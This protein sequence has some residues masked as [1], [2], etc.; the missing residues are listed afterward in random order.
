MS[1]GNKKTVKRYIVKRDLKGIFPKEF[2][3][4]DLIGKFF[5]Y[6]MNNFFEKS[7][8][9]YIN[10]Y[11]GKK[12]QTLE[13]GNFYVTEPTAERQLYQL[14]PMLV[15][16]D[17]NNNIKDIV[18]YTNFIN[19]LKTQGALTNDHNRLLSNK[20]WSYAP[21]INID[22]FLNFNFYYWIEE[23]VKPI[24]IENVVDVDNNGKAGEIR[25][26]NVVVNLIGRKNYTYN[27]LNNYDEVVS[28]PVYN[29][30]RIILKNDS[31]AEYNDKP[32]IIE[33]VG[34]S[35]IL[36][37]DSEIYNID[38]DTSPDYFVMERGAKDENPWSLRNRWFHI[39]D[40]KNANLINQIDADKTKYVQAKKP[41]LCFNKD[42]ELYNFGSYGR[43]WVDVITSMHKN[44]FNGKILNKNNQDGKLIIGNQVLDTGAKILFIDEPIEEAN[45]II[46][47]L[48]L[49]D[50]GD[51]NLITLYP[52]VNGR[53]PDGKA[54]I[55]DC[56]KVRNRL[57]NCYHFDGK[58][59]ILSQ[60][61]TKVCQSPLFNLYDKNKIPLDDKNIYPNSSFR[62]CT[63]FN[64]KPVTDRKATIDEDLK[65]RYSSDGY[66][67]YIFINS[68]VSDKITYKDITSVDIKVRKEYSGYKYYKINDENPSYLN[69]WI[70]SNDNLTQYI[71]SEITVKNNVE[72]AEFYDEKNLPIYYN[73]FDLAYE[74]SINIY[75]KNAF[76]YVN[77]QILDNES[78]FIDNYKLY[79][80]QKVEL[81]EFDTIFIK[82]LINKIGNEINFDVTEPL[83][84]YTKI[85]KD[86][87][88]TI[89]NVFQLNHNYTNYVEKNNI[90]LYIND[91]LISEGNYFIKNY[92]LYINENINVKENDNIS[93]KIVNN[94]NN[95]ELAD[96]YVY[97]IPLMLSANCLNE[98]IEEIKYNE[99]FSHFESI[100]ENQKNFEGA[101]NGINNYNDTAKDISLG[102]KI[103]QHSTPILKTM[104]LNSK[105]YTN[106]KTVLTY[107]CDEYTRFKNRYNLTINNF[108]NNG[109]YNEYERISDNTKNLSEYQSILESLSQNKN[110]TLEESDPKKYMIKALNLLNVGK[111]GLHPFY[112]NGVAEQ[113]INKDEDDV[114]YLPELYIPSTP[115]YLG[116]DNCYK[117]RFLEKTSELKDSVLLCHDGS[118]AKIYH[119]YRDEAL[120]EIEEEIYNSIPL[121]IKEHLPCIIKQKYIPGRFR[122]TEYSYENYIKLYTPLFEKW[123]VKNDLDYT[124]NST[125]D[126]YNSFTWN[127]STCYDDRGFKLPGSYHGIYMYYY[128]TDKPHTN[129]WEMLGFGDKPEW[130]E[131]HYG[132]AP[133]TSENYP[134]WKDIEEGHIIDG[135]SKGYY[136]EFKRPGL[137]EKYLPVDINGNLL[138][139]Y[140]AGIAT[141]KPII[142][143]ASD[144]WKIGD[145]GN[146][147]NSWRYTSEYRYDIQTL[148][149]LMKPLEWVETTWD[150]VN[151]DILFKNTNYE[152][153]INI[154]SNLRDIQTD[155]EMHNELINDE[156]VRK[157]GSQQWIS[158]F[159]T[160]ENINITNYIANDLRNMNV[161][162]G[163]RCAGFFDK[164]SMRLMS[165]NYGLIPDNNYHLNMN[166]RF[167]G[168]IFNYSA[169][170]I[171]KYDNT[172][173]LDGYDTEHPYF[174]VLLPKK[175]GK[176]ST[177]E[178]DGRN[179]TY[180]H[181]YLN[182]SQPIRYK[183]VFTSA[184]ELY[185][186]IVGYG[187]YLESIGFVFN[188]INSNGE[189]IDFTTKGREYLIWYNN[190]E[191]TSGMSLILNPMD[192]E[193]NFKHSGFVDKVGQFINGK[194]SVTDISSYP[195][196]NKDLK[197]Y[198][199][200]G[201]ITIKPKNIDDIISNVKLLTSE[202]E[203]IMI[204][205]NETIYG[206][207]LYN[208]LKGTKTERFKLLGIKANGWNGTYYAPGYVFDENNILIS[209]Y[210]KLAN[211]FNYVYDTDDIRSFGNMGEEAKKTIGYHKT[212]YMENLLIDNRNMFNFYKGMLKEKGTRLAFN[213]LNRSTHIMSEGSSKL[214]L[215]E[216]WAFNVGHFG[217]TKNKSTL[218]FHVDAESINHDPQIITFSTD[219]N[220]TSTDISNIAINWKNKNWLK[221]NDNQDENTFHY[222]PYSK[223]LTIGGFAQLN[224]VN[225]ILDT[226][227][228]L[229]NN[230]DNINIGEKVWVVK[231]NEYT[232]NI[233]KK[234]DNEINPLKSLKVKDFNGLLSYDCH[235]LEKGDLIYVQNDILNRWI[236][237]LS[238]DENGKE[239]NIYINDPN[240]LTHNPNYN[241][242]NVGWSVFEYNGVIP[243]SYIIS[244]PN[245]LVSI[246]NDTNTYAFK[247]EKGV[248]INMPN[249]LNADGK[250]IYSEFKLKEPLNIKLED[251]GK[252][253][254]IDDTN[255]YYLTSYFHN[256]SDEPLEEDLFYNNFWYNPKFNT[257]S[258]FNGFYWDNSNTPLYCWKNGDNKVYTLTYTPG[259]RYAWEYNNK[260]V[261][262][263]SEYPVAGNEMYNISGKKVNV[264]TS[265]LNSN[266]YFYA[267]VLIDDEIVNAKY[268]RNPEM[269]IDIAPSPFATSYNNVPV[270][271]FENFGNIKEIK[272]YNIKIT[273][274]YVPQKFA[275][276]NDNG[277]YYTE[278]EYPVAGDSVY[279]SNNI[280]I[281]VVTSYFNGNDFFYVDDV[282]YIRDADNDLK[283]YVKISNT[284]YYR[285]ED[286]D[287]SPNHYSLI[288]E[289]KIDVNTDGNFD[290]MNL[291]DISIN[292]PFILTRVEQKPINIDLINSAYLLDDT[293][294]K[295][296]AQLHLYDPLHGILPDF[297]S[298]EIDY[299]T[300]YDPVDYNN[301][302]NWFDEKVGRLWWDT[303]K[304]RYI[305]YYQ[306]SLKYRRDNWGKQLPGSEIAI[307]EWSKSTILPED[308]GNQPY[309]TREVYN[310]ETDKND[311]FY[312]FWV[313]NPTEIPYLDFRTTSAYDISRKIN[314]PQDEGI[315]WFSPI[316]LVDRIYNDS[317]F[318][319]GNFD[320]VTTSQNF[321]I[322]INFKNN[323]E[324]DNHDE[325][326]MIVEDSSDLIPDPLWNK[327]KDSLIT[328]DK[329]NDEVPDEDLTD[330]EKTGITIRP[331]QSMFKNIIKARRNFVDVC[332]DIFDS[333]AID[334][335]TVI[336]DIKDLSVKDES[337]K[338]YDIIDTFPT[339]NEMISTPDKM[340]VGN[341]I[342]VEHDE[343]YD[344]IWTLWKCETL[345]EFTLIDYQKYSMDRYTYLIDAYINKKYSKDVYDKKIYF[346]NLTSYLN[347]VYNSNAKN[348]ITLKDGYIIRIDDS[349]TKEWLYL[350]QYNASTNTFITVGVR[351]GYIQISDDLYEYMENKSLLNNY[352][353]KLNNEDYEEFIDGLTE[354]EYIDREVKILIEIICDYFNKD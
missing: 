255:N 194:W 265:S 137:I 338:N 233:Y 230:I 318:I 295:T 21:P 226:K 171:T 276:K 304:V 13:E 252:Y 327:M 299:I 201:Y 187:K 344:N 179:F 166:Q 75:K 342:L 57:N 37:D 47:E 161:Q 209:D 52:V 188:L 256:S 320:D 59:W 308:I 132:P 196:Y 254:F 54:L 73:V 36:V 153:I 325:W 164:G 148:L 297:I 55:G 218:E 62:G 275:W 247:V 165:D 85:N 186:T 224:D 280:K 323:S 105:E 154:N 108:V 115:A 242:K 245:G 270:Y 143:Y 259:I 239:L 63:I 138:P 128:D 158:D 99:T 286:D 84:K 330:N 88:T 298:K 118:Y 100:L 331:R 25:G 136:E 173:V 167:T 183:T 160:S 326:F 328:E 61:K 266:E 41:I 69:N 157:M 272:E 106:I 250:Y 301:S 314:S 103:L 32:F 50:N 197:I 290:K 110:T 310:P 141:A 185:N 282:K 302:N 133:Y 155:I 279:D 71:I 353:K 159:L 7:Y 271:I 335:V 150:S 127:W 43:G 31:N 98:D 248:Y 281:N 172:W 65:R 94:S 119:D 292:N 241:I 11:I 317:S 117:P 92:S 211:D 315:I 287:I 83:E 213:K 6:V 351:D 17:S 147:E 125:F 39:N 5:D 1:I 333:R 227:D 33:G 206:D 126:E 131:E 18:D 56:I 96:G 28:I 24:I 249:G 70:L 319:I 30:M 146:V 258:R 236:T 151:T 91:N 114:Y 251:S 82:L 135:L 334:Y 95:E 76:V 86:E 289:T 23:G 231:D 288:A 257:L 72:V 220:Y 240:G 192:I 144:P 107:I 12:T 306:G 124:V 332:N 269:D 294:D 198:R 22:M 42:I 214:N 40:I 130:W 189:N 129:P 237:R 235:Y 16:Y 190:E 180:Y 232:W 81:K 268:K 212:K 300:S 348:P 216:H 68:I 169:M 243:Y 263:E 274:P 45:N 219:P 303:S 352:N 102:T 228:N 291:V 113:L 204:I 349:S 2:T 311:I 53:D 285:D 116:L 182:V 234:V 347:R 277:V 8:E 339:H 89:Y 170:I 176:T 313:L 156:Y 293:I 46:Y 67:N 152:Q 80:T 324:V 9:R 199:H 208:S 210:D 120:L 253:L 66:G 35:I 34:K 296:L 267:D 145:L 20:H 49:V 238:D 350:L 162:L 264:V 140:E 222:K 305:D 51:S 215:D 74:P 168:K 58:N 223:K 26:T 261:Y 163:Y 200:N 15:D 90:F 77:G 283:A 217:Y 229:I 48:F 19:V 175:N 244:M 104:L 345:D 193:I 343:Y 221:D 205:D 202:K 111:N 79:I 10:G 284:K 203:N 246:I 60:Q 262:T 149:Y 101:I 337:Y 134:M 184:Q 336:D 316:N 225:Y 121:T 178:I 174:D 4:R 29:G 112:N 44:D 195:I 93:I 346:N 109:I 14:T 354:Y 322:Q 38:D 309:L 27:Y 87:S 97:D 3:S 273:T 123:V 307:M 329:F 260:F 278:S 340:L 177:V 142:K 191:I 312:Y 64:Y 207:V 122:N 321:D 78:F 181:E 341:Y 139:P